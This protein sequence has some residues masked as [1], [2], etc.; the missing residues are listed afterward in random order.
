MG[1]VGNVENIGH[2]TDGA[3]TIYNTTNYDGLVGNCTWCHFPGHP[4]DDVGGA[5]IILPNNPQVGVSYKSGGIHLRRDPGGQGRAG[6]P[7]ANQAELC[8]GCHDANGISEW[9]SDDGIQNASTNPITDPTVDYDYGSLSGGKTNFTTSDW[10]TATWTSGT[11]AFSYKDG[12]IQ[13]T[14]STNWGVG[15]SA[16]TWNS[17]DSQWEEDPDPNI[18]IQCHNCHDVHNMNFA[19]GDSENGNPYL[20]GTWVRNPYLEDGAP[21]SG[22]TYSAGVNKFGPVPRG[23]TTYNET[24]GFLIDQN[25]NAG[26]APTAGLGLGNSAGICTLCHGNIADEM[27]V[28]DDNTG[29]IGGSVGLWL[30]V[31]G[32]S[33]SALGGTANSAILANIL[34]YTNIAADAPAGTGRNV[35][36]GAPVFTTTKYADGANPSMGYTNHTD[37]T[38]LTYAAGFRS[39]YS[40]KGYANVTALNNLVKVTSYNAYVDFDWGVTEDDA[41]TDKGYHAF[42]CSKCHNPHASRLPKLMIT[43]CLDTKKNTWDDD[44]PQ[45]PLFGS[46]AKNSDNTVTGLDSDGQYIGNATSAQNCHRLGDPSTGGTGGGW[47]TVTPWSVPP[48]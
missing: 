47:N 30:G 46:E 9:G 2:L 42:T 22:T 17:G 23:G 16:V 44:Q 37:G 11:P 19:T 12:N 20:R 41:T 31:N 24:G 35:A 45:I 4:T 6:G 25:N 15:S 39:L 33:N 3:A 14:H 1:G 7:A 26:G 29:A 43:N 32:H 8:W 34:N 40:G 21:Q 27:D 18:E 28:I 36:G 10:E 13:S 48:P 5:A 38:A